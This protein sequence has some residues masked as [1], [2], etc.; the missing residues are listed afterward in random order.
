MNA[1]WQ[2]LLALLAVVGLLAL[3][4]LLFGKLVTPVGGGGG[5]PGVAGGGGGGGGAPPRRGVPDPVTGRPGSSVKVEAPCSAKEEAGAAGAEAAGAEEAPPHPASRAAQKKASA[6]A[7]QKH[8]RL[9][10]VFLSGAG[11]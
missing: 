11:A 1:I 3:G 5:G 10:M 9:F 8:L 7:A 6:A 2:V 4:W